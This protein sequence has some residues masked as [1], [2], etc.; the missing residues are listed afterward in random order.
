MDWKRE[1]KDGGEELERLLAPL[2]QGLGLTL[3]ELSTARHRQSVQVRAVLFKRE[4][5][6]VDD[7]SRFHRAIIPQLELSFPEASLS[8]E[9][10]SPGTS[11]VIRDGAELARYA[12]CE[13]ACYITALSDWKRGILGAATERS[14]TL[15]GPN[16]DETFPLAAVA[17]A[18]LAS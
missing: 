2:A 11:R 14:V 17:K 6:G 12:G 8:I 18:K 1:R 10:S 5:T 9:V 7:C 3:I 4:G 15:S 16:G 13:V